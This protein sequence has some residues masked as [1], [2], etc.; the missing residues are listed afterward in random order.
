MLFKSKYSSYILT[1]YTYVCDFDDGVSIKLSILKSFIPKLSSLLYLYI[2]KKT[3]EKQSYFLLT[4]TF[5]IVV[6]RL[7]KH[8]VILMKNKLLTKQKLNMKIAPVIFII[9]IKIILPE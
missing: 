2:Y 4:I 7:K 1:K 5:L 8:Y 9:V 6:E 3:K